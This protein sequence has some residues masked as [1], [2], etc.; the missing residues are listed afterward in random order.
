MSA[1]YPATDPRRKR[2]L[3][4]Q[5]EAVATRF[6]PQWRGL[7]EPGD[8]GR[9]L[10]ELGA[11]LAEH[12]ISRHDRTAERDL[13]AFLNWLDLP[14]P[15]PTPAE[16]Q[17]VFT[18][19][20]KLDDAVVVRERIQ[21]GAAGA[22]GTEVIFETPDDAPLTLTP[23]RL[24][25]VFSVDPGS[26]RIET[27]PPHFLDLGPPR[28]SDP[29]YAILSFA[30][31]DADQIQITPA[32]GLE[33]GDS[34]RIAGGVYAIKDEKDGIYT[35]EPKLEVAATP[36]HRWRGSPASS[37]RRCAICSATSSTWATRSS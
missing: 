9:A 25:T 19:S 14:G 16:A 37:F 13:K 29:S 22:D 24:E 21:V 7:T 12:V 27:A 10:L 35:I 2:E 15:A 4:R 26:D 32:I 18:L 28:A 23:A 17:L 36:G 30:A 3:L 1:P 5:L 34:V 20:D 31:A 11:D 6:V 33:K 8:F